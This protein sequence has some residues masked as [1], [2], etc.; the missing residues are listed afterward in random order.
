MKTVFVDTFYWVAIT[1]PNDPWSSAVRKAKE[2]LGPT[3]LVTTDEVLGEF[4][5]VLSKGSDSIRRKAVHLVRVVLENPNVRVIPQSRTSFLEGLSLFE[6]RYDKEYSYV[7][8]TSM[9]VMRAEG[10]TEI[11]TNDHHFEQEGFA[12]LIKEKPIE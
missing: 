5:T 10:I 1:R 11:L 6:Q 12:V 8:C 4:L 9:N 7:D 2:S 3:S